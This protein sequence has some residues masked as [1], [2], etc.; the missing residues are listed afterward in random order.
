VRVV[1][2]LL[3]LAKVGD[4]NLPL[5]TRPVHLCDLVDDM[6]NLT[7]IADQ[8]R[9]KVSVEGEPD[10]VVAV[11]DPAELDILVTNLLSNAMKYSGPDSIVTLTLARTGGEILLSCEDHGIGISADDQALLFREF[12]RSDSAEVKAQ[13]GTGLGLTIVDRILSRHG[14]RIEVD[15]VLG[16]GST[17]R[18]YLPAR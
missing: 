2:D 17:F 1:E 15:S 14:G 18:V 4:P 3:L 7:S 10:D 11:G 6:V 8:R 12:F 5:L 16:Q 9:V 13:P